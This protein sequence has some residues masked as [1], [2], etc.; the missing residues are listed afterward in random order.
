MASVSQSESHRDFQHGDPKPL[1]M[2]GAPACH[3]TSIVLA[4]CVSLS[5]LMLAGTG[6][7]ICGFLWHD[8]TPKILGLALM[9]IGLSMILTGFVMFLYDG[10]MK[11]RKLQESVDPFTDQRGADANIRGQRQA[12]M[13]APPSYDDVLQENVQYREEASGGGRS[14]RLS[15][16]TAV[17]SAK[18]TSTTAV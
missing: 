6:A 7:C 5:G 8:M 1:G 16:F 18:V 15:Y 13:F 10:M 9:G 12:G 2:F 3:C 11:R 4:L 14:D 17:R